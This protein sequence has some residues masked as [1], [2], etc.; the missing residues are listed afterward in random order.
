MKH[1]RI[2][3]AMLTFSLF[4]VG[5]SYAQDKN[6]KEARTKSMISD[7]NYV[8]KAQTVMPT[9]GSVRQ[10]TSEYDVRVTKDSVVAYLPYFGRAYTAPM[11]TT[12]GG[13]NFTSTNFAYNIDEARKGGWDIVIKPKDTDD[14]QQVSLRI[15]ESGY[16][17]V[18]VI[19]RNRQVIS[20]NG[21]IEAGKTIASR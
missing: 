8:F 19:S 2:I 18:Q 13:I 17:T 5:T 3:M 10:L 16:A 11:N 7:Q 21:Y 15:S 4:A 20:Y 12:N 9:N 14:V 1:L 6:N